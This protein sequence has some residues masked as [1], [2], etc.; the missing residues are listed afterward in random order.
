MEIVAYSSRSEFFVNGGNDNGFLKELLGTEVGLTK[1]RCRKT[2]PRREKCRSMLWKK[3]RSCGQKT[4]SL[5]SVRRAA[6]ALVNLHA[7]PDQEW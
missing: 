5:K 3:L 1:S 6:A 2:G 7:R 4:C